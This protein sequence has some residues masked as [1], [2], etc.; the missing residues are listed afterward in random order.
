M[1]AWATYV[2]G[3]WLMGECEVNDVEIINND[4]YKLRM[5]SLYSRAT[6]NNW[7]IVLYTCM[8]SRQDLWW[9]MP[10]SVRHVLSSTVF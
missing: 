5:V 4:V 6:E 1:N 3:T 8:L 10:V 2:A 9:R 7:S